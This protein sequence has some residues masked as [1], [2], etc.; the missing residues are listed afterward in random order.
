MDGWEGLQIYICTHR[1]RM[2]M[3][4]KNA[5]WTLEAAGRRDGGPTTLH[6]KS[7]KQVTQV[8]CL[9][10]CWLQASRGWPIPAFRDKCS[11]EATKAATVCDR[12]D[13]GRL[14]ADV[15]NNMESPCFF[16]WWNRCTSPVGFCRRN[17]DK[18][19]VENLSLGQ[20]GNFERA[21]TAVSYTRMP[22]TSSQPFRH[23]RPSVAV[24]LGYQV[25]SRVKREGLQE[26]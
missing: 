7:P 24:D 6:E 4:G 20:I 10:F 23:H 22:R 2:P 13:K 17:H 21:L 8:T 15:I 11:D 5:A 3:V 14:G 1:P 18:R 12:A 19:I 26:I 16:F 25:K 9:G